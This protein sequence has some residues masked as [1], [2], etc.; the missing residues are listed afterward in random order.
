[1]IISKTKNKDGILV[2][3]FVFDIKHCKL[4]KSGKA[5]VAYAY[6]NAEVEASDNKVV[7]IEQLLNVD[8]VKET[9][10]K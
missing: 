8:L 5:Y 3:N 6:A 2:F 10:K 1:M 4:A 9:E 7:T